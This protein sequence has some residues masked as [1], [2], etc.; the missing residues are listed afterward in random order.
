MEAIRRLC[1]FEGRLA[2]T[3]AERRAANDMA[4]LLRESGRRAEVQPIHVHPQVWTAYALHCLL[5]VAGSLISIALSPAGFAL[6]L[7]S[8]V[9]LYLDLNT[10]FPLLRRVLF[11][12]A[13]QN[14]FSPGKHPEARARLILSA[15]LDVARTGYL[16]GE[17]I[18]GLRRSI[19]ASLRVALSPPRLMFW[20]LA[21]LLPILGARM[22]GLEA[23]WLSMLQL[24]PTVALVIAVFLLVDIQLSD[25]VPGAG[26]N[27]AGVAVA[28]SLA[29]ALDANP[30][31]HLD[32][33]VLLTGGEECG[34]Q[35]MRSFVR[36]HRKGWDPAS[37]YFLVFEEPGG[38]ALH[39]LVA[40][41]PA[42]TYRHDTRLAELCEA[43]AAAGAEQDGE[44][45]ARPARLA[46]GTD[47]LPPTLAGYPAIALIGLGPD[48]LSPATHHTLDDTPER[49][50][51]G[52]LERAE[53]FALE[54]VRQLNRDVGRTLS[55]ARPSARVSRRA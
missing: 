52:A 21:A 35:G 36:S 22:A 4:A 10:R 27:A 9:S 6:V 18:R 37:T 38:E 31:E 26:D 48:G 14:I 2:G 53:R 11:R 3:D 49:V 43:I 40:E 13:S 32:V 19:P 54:L 51:T 42:V 55:A 29:R 39:Y 15:H 25:P 46:I 1:S 17:R 45:G 12:R 5:G 28:L 24:L 30:P 41:G 44:L 16:Y 50:D 23:G 33:C 20:S 8:A 7:A 34:T 47:A